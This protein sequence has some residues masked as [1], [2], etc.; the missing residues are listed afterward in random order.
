MIARSSGPSDSLG[1]GR[2]RALARFVFVAG[3]TPLFVRVGL[4]DARNAKRV[5]AKRSEA[6]WWVEHASCIGK[7]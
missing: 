5:C 6:V 7:S 2:L 4:L 3:C 1:Q